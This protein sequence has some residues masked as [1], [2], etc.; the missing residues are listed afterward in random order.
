M[1]LRS[2]ELGVALRSPRV[3]LGVEQ[4]TPSP[5]CCCC[6]CRSSCPNEPP[7]IE[8]PRLW[9]R[10]GPA[11]NDGREQGF[12]VRD[13]LRFGGACLLHVA[14]VSSAWAGGTGADVAPGAPTAVCAP[15]TASAAPGAVAAVVFSGVGENLFLV[16]GAQPI[17]RFSS[18]PSQFPPSS[19]TFPVPR[20]SPTSPVPSPLS[21]RAS[22]C[23]SSP[24]HRAPSLPVFSTSARSSVKGRGCCREGLAVDRHPALT[25]SPPL[26]FS[27]AGF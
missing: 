2:R 24:F 20:Y 19:T 6:S 4:I 10:Y 27:S 23:C 5:C 7:P 3:A 11:L 18:L 26:S 15:S 14:L 16:S 22:H 17:S 9:E 25:G 13:L 1:R 8:V 12:R 21:S